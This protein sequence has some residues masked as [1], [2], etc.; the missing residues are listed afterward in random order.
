MIQELH[1]IVRYIHTAFCNMTAYYHFGVFSNLVQ[2]NQFSLNR[3]HSQKVNL[4]ES[5]QN[6]ERLKKKQSVNQKKR[7]INEA[8]N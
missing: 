3:D 6:W 1:Q 2:K 7:K 4:S 8:Y 5:H